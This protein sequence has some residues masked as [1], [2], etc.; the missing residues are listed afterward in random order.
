[1][2]F[3]K[4]KRACIV[5]PTYNEKENV[6][7]L[8][9]G[10]EKVRGG[11]AGWEVVLLFVDDRSPDGT[12]EIIREHQKVFHNWVFLLEGDKKGL[13]EAY[14]RGFRYALDE[15]KPDVVFQMDSDLQHNP[16]DIPRFLAQMDMGYEFV[17][18]SRYIPGGDCPEWEFKRKIYSW[19][20][21]RGA[22]LIAGIKGVND[23]TS[24]FRCI[25]AEFLRNIRLERLRGD[26]YAFQLS[27]VHAATK[28]KLR[29][30]EIPILFPSRAKGASKLGHRDI[31]EFFF[32]AIKL[33]FKKY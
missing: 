25:S 9:A 2:I 6:A 28:K 30:K 26:G 33:R 1:M 16:N 31:W 5:L 29:I 8:I 20:A 27:L 12:A 13:G 21:N 14:K 22:E 19:M 32:T 3:E 24:G 7:E 17:I 11:A 4:K 15:L 23:C 18:G 10:I